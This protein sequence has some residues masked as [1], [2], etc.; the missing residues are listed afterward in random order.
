M[1]IQGVRKTR[2]YIFL[3]SVLFAG[4]KHLNLLKKQNFVFRLDT[5]HLCCICLL[6]KNEPK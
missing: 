6:L 2:Y 1:K 4:L 5:F 3:V